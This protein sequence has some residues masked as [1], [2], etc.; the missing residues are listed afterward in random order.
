MSRSKKTPAPS[1]TMSAED[2]KAQSMLRM[3]ELISQV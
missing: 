3:Q 1:A 2:V